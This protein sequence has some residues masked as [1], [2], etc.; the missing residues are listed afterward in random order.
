MNGS[1]DGG[2]SPTWSVL[3]FIDACQMPGSLPCQ[4][5]LI[6]AKRDTL[7]K[8]TIV[9]VFLYFLLN[10]QVLFDPMPVSKTYLNVLI[11][12]SNINVMRFVHLFDLVANTIALPFVCNSTPQRFPGIF[13][14]NL[15]INTATDIWSWVSMAKQSGKSLHTSVSSRAIDVFCMLQQNT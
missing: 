7:C 1:S 11:I 8:H 3:H 2:I 14:L 15:V 6:S 10:D 4:N 5:K 13:W 9:Q 12:Y